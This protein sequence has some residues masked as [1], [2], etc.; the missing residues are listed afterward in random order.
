MSQLDDGYDDDGFIFDD[1]YQIAHSINE[2]IRNKRSGHYFSTSISQISNELITNLLENDLKGYCYIVEDVFPKH[3]CGSLKISNTNIHTKDRLVDCRRSRIYFC[4]TCLLN[5]FCRCQYWHVA[6]PINKDLPML[7]RSS[8]EIPGGN[9]GSIVFTY[10]WVTTELDIEGRCNMNI[11][12]LGLDRLNELPD[13]R[14]ANNDIFSNGKQYFLRDGE[15]CKVLNCVNAY[16]PT[17]IGKD[18]RQFIVTERTLKNDLFCI[19]MSDYSRQ[20]QIGD[21]RTDC[22]ILSRDEYNVMVISSPLSCVGI[23]TLCKSSRCLH[24]ID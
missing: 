8:N 6:V 24:Q 13:Y 9:D 7:G 18:G 1:R 5:T 2:A 11:P 23:L 14:L 15:V 21:L 3:F 10:N 19:K 16:V 12:F 4:E 20:M 22:F 17:H